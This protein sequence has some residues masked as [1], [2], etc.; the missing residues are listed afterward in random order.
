MYPPDGSPS[1]SKSPAGLNTT[2][3]SASGAAARSAS[4]PAPWPT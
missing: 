3:S 1:W 2:Q 4:V